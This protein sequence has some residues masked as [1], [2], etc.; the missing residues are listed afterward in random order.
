MS[1]ACHE[2]RMSTNNLYAYFCPV[3]THVVISGTQLVGAYHK[4]LGLWR[5]ETHALMEAGTY[6]AALTV[7]EIRAR[8]LAQDW[9]NGVREIEIES[10]EIVGTKYERATQARWR[11]RKVGAR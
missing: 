1:D 4:A 2:L 7:D 10:K 9:A 3:C 6:D 8:V 5:F 11:R